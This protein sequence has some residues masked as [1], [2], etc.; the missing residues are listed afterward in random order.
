M[1]ISRRNLL[2]RASMLIFPESQKPSVKLSEKNIF[3]FPVAAVISSILPWSFVTSKKGTATLK[4]GILHK[5]LHF[6]NNHV[7]LFQGL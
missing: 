3:R 1:M 4:V 5:D 2:L 6:E 7:Y